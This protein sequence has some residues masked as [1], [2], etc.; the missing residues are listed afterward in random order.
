MAHTH[1]VCKDPSMKHI[2]TTTYLLAILM[3]FPLQAAHAQEKAS[4]SSA[5]LNIDAQT[6]I[7]AD[8]RIQAARAYLEKRNSPL[9]PYAA[10]FVQEADAYQLPWD[11]VLAISGVE[12]NFGQAVPCIN[13]WGWGIFGTNMVCFNSYPEGIHTVSQGI[14]QQYINQWGDTDIYKLGHHYASNPAWASHVSYF[15]QDIENFKHDF[16]ARN[17]TISL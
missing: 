13:A 4:G 14:R 17:L 3:V 7:V 15:M 9:A 8:T 2:L 1:T 12:S 5:I 10:N 11:L 6:T 16:D